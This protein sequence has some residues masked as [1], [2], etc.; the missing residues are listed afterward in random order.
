[1]KGVVRRARSETIDLIDD[2]GAKKVT[3]R[4]RR[5]DA[6]AGGATDPWPASLDQGPARIRTDQTA[7]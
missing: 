3:G 4:V 2:E 5:R 7:R 6:G 1:M